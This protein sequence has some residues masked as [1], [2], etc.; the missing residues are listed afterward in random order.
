MRVTQKKFTQSA[1]FT[2]GP[3]ALTYSRSD[4]FGSH[5]FDV[6]YGSIGMEP[7]CTTEKNGTLFSGGLIL[8]LWGTAQA[9]HALLDGDMTGLIF[10]VPGIL[11]FL[12]HRMATTTVTSLNTDAGEIALLHEKNHDLLMEEIRE[13]RK[14]QLLD[15]YGNINFANDPEDEIRKFHWLH[16]QNLISEDQLQRLVATIRNAD[17]QDQD[18]L[19]EPT[20]PRQ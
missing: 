20:P 1:T 18:G 6:P 12:L 19:D 3:E 11:C 10:I 13:R 9:L 16:S 17:I 2:F 15:W 14:K 7:R 8:T 5:S 4:A